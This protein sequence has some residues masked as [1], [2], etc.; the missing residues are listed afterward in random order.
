M[1][2][3]NNIKIAYGDKIILNNTSLN[4]ERGKLYTILGESGVGK[5]SLINKIG[6]ISTLNDNEEYILD[7]F[8]VNTKSDKDV[9]DFIHDEIAFIFQNQNLIRDISVY[10]NIAIILRN[11][12]LTE[13]CINDRIDLILKELKIESL[14]FKFP[15]ELSGGEEQRVAIARA[16]AA[17]KS[18][19]L[20]DE[21]TNSLDYNNSRIV[22]NLL[23]EAA[24]RLN[25]LEL[26]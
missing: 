21:P 13:D 19:I 8:K 25:K 17:D 16:L 26:L 18:I 7:N 5:S 24:H 10:E 23:C 22:Y 11:S 3:L 6:L 2:I 15:T 4:F 1:Y 20:A 9:S 12:N 14:K